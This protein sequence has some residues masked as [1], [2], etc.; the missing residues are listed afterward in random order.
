MGK[1]DKEWPRDLLIL[2]MPAVIVADI[3][4]EVQNDS[5]LS[6]CVW[7]Y[8]VFLSSYLLYIFHKEYHRFPALHQLKSY[9][10]DGLILVAM[11]LSIRGFSRA[12]SKMSDCL[13]WLGIFLLSLTIWEIHTMSLGREKY[14]KASKASL[15]PL[16][17]LRH[18]C[19]CALFK[20][21]K[22]IKHWDEYRYWVMLDSLLFVIVAT[23]FAWR[24]YTDNPVVDT[25]MRWIIPAVGFYIGVFNVYRYRLVLRA[26]TK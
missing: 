2:G 4:W 7:L 19:R 6:F 3:I 15:S 1:K 18:F 11:F 24:A 21:D 5:P 12:Y 22:R 17:M 26:V 25:E 20:F 13:L 16:E 14:F 10:F 8:A 23:A 9:P